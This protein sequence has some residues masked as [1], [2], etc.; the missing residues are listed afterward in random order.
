[1]AKAKWFRDLTVQTPL[2][3]AMR[4]VL[5][6]RTRTVQRYLDRVASRPSEDPEDVHQLRVAARR[7][8]A[9][10]SV[11]KSRLEPRARRGVRRAARRLRQLAGSVRDLDVLLAMV[12]QRVTWLPGGAPATP[13]PI[14]RAIQRD[15]AAA[16]QALEKSLPKWTQQFDRSSARLLQSLARQASGKPVRGTLGSIARRILLKRL[17]R[18]FAA[19]QKD[20]TDLDRMHRLRIMAKR[21]RYTMEIF[22]NGYP[23]EFARNLYPRVEELQGDLGEI[24]DLRNLTRRLRSMQEAASQAARSNHRAGTRRLIDR[25]AQLTESELEQ[26]ARIFIQKWNRLTQS[27]FGQR[28]R[29]LV[30]ARERSSVR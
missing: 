29:R 22:G 8:V 1:M 12:E 23:A 19:G 27:N 13:R 20:L 2:P 15:R 24:N 14:L 3:I 26:R 16:Q 4:R 10:L 30:T 7:L 28:F 21:L 18:C 5:G 6:S 25:L 11:F 9:A 17:D